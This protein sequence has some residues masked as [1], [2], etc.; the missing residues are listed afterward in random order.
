MEEQTL[1]LISGRTEMKRFVSQIFLPLLLLTGFTEFN[2]RQIQTNTPGER[3]ILFCDRTLYIAGEQLLFSAFLQTGDQS[4]EN[5]PSNV[6]YCELITPDG[7]KITSNKYLL[8]DSY[9]SGSIEIPNDVLTGIYYL[10]AYT[11]IMRNDGPSTYHYTRIKIV[12][13]RYREIRT[14]MDKNQP[15]ENLTDAVNQSNTGNSF[16][17]S[18]DKSQYAHRDTVHIS[19]NGINTTISS[20]KGLSLAVVPEFS[21]SADIVNFPENDQSE[22]RMFYYP[23]T[24]GLLITGTLTDNTT[25]RPLPNTRVNLSILGKGRDFI[26][27]QTDSAGRFFFSLPDYTGSRDLFLSSE[28]TS[29]SDPKILVDNDFC[30][31]PVQI[32]SNIFSLTPKE[33]ET[34][35]NMAVN[36]QL[37]SYFK[38]DSIHNDRIGPSED[39]VFYGKPDDILYIN[40]Y[41]QLPTL[42]EYFNGLPTLV[43]VRK[44][45]GEKYFKVL[46]TQAGL[47]SYDP[48]VLV[49]LVVINDPSRVLTILPANISRIEIIN[50]LYVKGDQTYGGII[51]IITKRG[52]FAG[53]DL[54]SSGIFINYDFFTGNIHYPNVYNPPGHH[55]DT[56][57]TLYWN[58]RIVLNGNNNTKVSFVVSDTPGRY[59][60]VLQG[61]SF[62][63]KLCRQTMIFEVLK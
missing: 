43:K 39:Q 1:N 44:R 60:I 26:A 29:T 38:V 54:P 47:S 13:A 21:I 5:E 28:K 18:T 30:T 55:P 42:E 45:K 34:A 35:Y 24:R 50:K 57:N 33:R 48:L 51:N 8:E 7:I 52:D 9:A 3:V 59:Q 46:G 17:I 16:L 15:T 11:R 58:P 49:D 27:I 62:E 10:R 32:P 14:G 20:W 6:L 4:A 41:I 12:N 25:G 31:I 22:K 53:I 37:G 61:I 19:I 63:G 36:V 23:E 2:G 40:D 56:R